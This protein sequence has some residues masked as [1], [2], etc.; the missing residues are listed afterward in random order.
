MRLSAVV[1]GH[2]SSSLVGG[3]GWDE[4]VVR[5]LADVLPAGVSVTTNGL[6]CMSAL[7]ASGVRRPF[8]LL[9]PCFHEATMAAGVADSAGH[10][11]ET[12]GH[13][14]YDPDRK[15]T[16]QTPRAVL[17]HSRA[18]RHEVAP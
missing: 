5:S 7:R 2:S 4:A 17:L 12:H 1:V 16:E 13:M 10:C 9:A 18:L 15:W 3:Q 11:F 14:L 6:D 8:L